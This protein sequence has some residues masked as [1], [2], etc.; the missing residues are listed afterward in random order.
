MSKGKDWTDQQIENYYL[1]IKYSDYPSVIWEKIKPKIVG[2]T[3]LIDVG[4]GPGAFALKA[5]EEGFYVQAVDINHKNLE[6]L[7]K[8]IEYLSLDRKR[9]KTIYGNWLE[10]K[11]EKSDVVICAYSFGSDIGTRPG[12]KKI[13]ELTKKYAFCI[14]PYSATQTDFM[15]KELY[16]EAGIEPPS[17]NGSYQDLL[18]LLADLNKW[19]SYEIIEYD[20]G[21]PLRSKNEI[22]SCAV[23]LSEKLGIPSLKLVKKHLQSIVTVKNSFYWVPNP[24]KSVIITCKRSGS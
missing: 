18:L 5:A 13:L 23:F 20:F 16:R 3:S 15:S 14:S 19:V 8:Q 9:I 21:F 7:N 22:D 2:Y 17:F 6:A 11:V 10:V 1:G 24:R 12:L 4:C